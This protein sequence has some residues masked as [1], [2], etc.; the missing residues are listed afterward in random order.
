MEKLEKKE[1]LF[2]IL[3]KVI[4]RLVE[5][6]VLTPIICNR[7]HRVKG[8]HTE[9]RNGYFR[10][11]SILNLVWMQVQDGYGIF[12]NEYVITCSGNVIN[13]VDVLSKYYW[14]ID[15]TTGTVRCG[16]LD[17]RSIARCIGS[18]LVFGNIKHKLPKEWEVHHKWF[19]WCNTQECIAVVGAL[20]HKLF[21]DKINSR[22][23]HRK[24]VTVNDE[25][26]METEL[27]LIKANQE[28]WRE[29]RM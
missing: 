28:Y 14:Y 9:P 11:T 29:N 25:S 26:S 8:D 27:R 7:G 5:D 2:G 18:V 22:K 3:I 17:N 21:H 20:E 16:G 4:L 6:G 10:V 1:C 19:R 15:K 12:V 13:L 23:S 24:G